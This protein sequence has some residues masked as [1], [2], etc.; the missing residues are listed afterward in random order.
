[1]AESA[2]SATALA[3]AP[4][5]SAAPRVKSTSPVGRSEASNG[6]VVIHVRFHPTG[7][8]NT[9]NHRPD[10]ISPQDW[11]D[12]LCRK[13]PSSYQALAGGRGAFRIQREALDAIWQDYEV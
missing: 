2:D 4:A 11:F 9:V 6:E 5:A 1:M 12:L 13:A 7:L 10:R 8:V 3:S